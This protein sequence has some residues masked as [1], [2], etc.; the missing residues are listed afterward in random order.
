VEFER[1]CQTFENLSNRV[2]GEENKVFLAKRN[3]DASRT[4]SSNF[5]RGL[6]YQNLVVALP[7]NLV[8]KNGLRNPY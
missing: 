1:V 4:L 7:S 6:S 3:R 5:Q 2:F 8:K